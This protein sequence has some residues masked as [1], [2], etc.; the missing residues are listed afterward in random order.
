MENVRETYTY[1]IVQPSSL[2]PKATVAHLPAALLI[3]GNPQGMMMII[4]IL[5]RDMCIDLI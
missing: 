5:I 2:A 4:M 3:R 1:K